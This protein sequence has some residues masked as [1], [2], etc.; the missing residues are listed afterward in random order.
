MEKGRIVERG[1]HAELLAVGGL[2]YKLYQGGFDE[3]LEDET[4]EQQE[5]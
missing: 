1:T 5:K 4:A 2:Y 3:I